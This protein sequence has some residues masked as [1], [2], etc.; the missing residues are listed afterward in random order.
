MKTDPLE[1]VYC[2]NCKFFKFKKFDDGNILYGCSK[3]HSVDIDRPELRCN[4]PCYQK[5]WYKKK[6]PKKS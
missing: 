3:E 6:A 2:K 5:K 4:L 1:I